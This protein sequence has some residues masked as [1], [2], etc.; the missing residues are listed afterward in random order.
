ME[1]LSVLGISTGRVTEVLLLPGLQDRGLSACLPSKVALMQ[2]QWTAEAQISCVGK[3]EEGMVTRAL[4]LESH[5]V[6]L[7][8]SL[9]HLTLCSL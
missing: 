3:R 4:D 5:W 9:G 2:L 7:D 8:K 6:I 1:P